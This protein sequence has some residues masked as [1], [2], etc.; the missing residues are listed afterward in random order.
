MRLLSEKELNNW[1]RNDVYNDDDYD[2]WVEFL[3]R[4]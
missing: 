4:F 2:Y 1:I 3:I